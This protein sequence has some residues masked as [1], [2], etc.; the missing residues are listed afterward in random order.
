MGHPRAANAVEQK[1]EKSLIED[2][3]VTNS[4]SLN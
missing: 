3:K 2:P 4:A 1:K